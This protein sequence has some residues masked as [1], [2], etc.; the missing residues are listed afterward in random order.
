MVG[1]L[2]DRYYNKIISSTID[3]PE[4]CPLTC[5]QI[6]LMPGVHLTAVCTPKFKSSYWSL[7]LLAPLKRET[8]ALN[9]LLPFLLRR[10]TATL[11]DLTAF[12]AAL[13]ELYGGAIEPAVRKCG[14]VQCIGFDASFLDDACAPGGE[15]I[16]EPAAQLMGDLLLHPATKNGRLR[17]DYLRSERDNLVRLIQSARNDKRQYARMRLIEEMYAGT[18]YAV[19][20]FGTAAQAEKIHIARLFAQYQELLER[21]PVELFYCGSAP[22]RRVEL[23]WRAALMGLPRAAQRYETETDAHRFQHLEVRDFTEHLDVTQGKLEMGFQTDCGLSDPAYPA[24]LVANAMFGGT[25]SSRLFLHVREKRS[26]CYYAS[27]SMDSAKGLVLVACG[28]DPSN[29][30]PAREEILLQLNELQQGSFTEEELDAAKRSVVNSLRSALDEQ[31]GMCSLWLRDRA[32][33]VKFDLPNLI[34]RVSDVTRGQAAAAAMDMRLDSV[35][36]LS[37]AEQEGGDADEGA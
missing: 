2:N 24:M 37:G 11:P 35:Y 5:E 9:A 31:G 27:S 10:G 19:G 13:D 32:A 29:F 26:L 18:D 8:A 12:S 3:V 15:T 23:A 1:F 4:V 33:G 17:Q 14:D 36:Y 7:R 22:A 20:R 30:A 6:E 16:L 25:S 28:V 34:R 21:A